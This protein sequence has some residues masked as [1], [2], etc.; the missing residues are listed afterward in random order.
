M[1]RLA[2]HA[3]SLVEVEYGQP[4]D[5]AAPVV[6]IEQAVAAKS[7]H[8]D[9]LKRTTAGLA[10]NAADGAAGLIAACKHKVQG[11]RCMP[12]CAVCALVVG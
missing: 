8:G 11:A 9:G 6:T 5:G 4:H 2:E 3:A 1:Q 7:F 10:A 12:C